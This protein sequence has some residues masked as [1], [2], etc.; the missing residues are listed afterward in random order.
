[1]PQ[2]YNLTIESHYCVSALALGSNRMMESELRGGRKGF[3]AHFNVIA[4][5]S[6][7]STPSSTGLFGGIEIRNLVNAQIYKKYVGDILGWS[8]GLRV[9]VHVV[10]EVFFIH[11]WFVFILQ[12]NKISPHNY[13]GSQTVFFSIW[14][15]KT[16][17]KAY[18]MILQ[19]SLYSLKLPTASYIRL[20][21]TIFHSV[22]LS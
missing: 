21:N 20:S 6:P 13:E 3:G 1:M 15:A 17:F 7:L 22:F 19:S 2:L 18:L 5:T 16:F 12:F 4:K 10:Q 9:H 11:I 8:Q 14:K